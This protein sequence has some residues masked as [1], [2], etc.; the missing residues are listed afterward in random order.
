MFLKNSNLVKSDIFLNNIDR[1]KV[2]FI[3]SIILSLHLH[4]G[5]GKLYM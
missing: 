3:E 4:T 2:L 1:F 5:G